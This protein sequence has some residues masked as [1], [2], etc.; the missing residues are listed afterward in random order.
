MT[1]CQCEDIQD[2]AVG[3]L[4]ACLCLERAPHW[5]IE[6]LHSNTGVNQ[7]EGNQTP[8]Y[9]SNTHLSARVGQLNPEWNEDLEDDEV[10]DRFQ[11]AVELT[12]GEFEGKVK[13]LSK[14]GSKQLAQ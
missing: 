6:T 12:G 7:W 14:V 8:K 4:E 1:Q 9:V 10:D 2:Q 5:V 13:W 3:L 11:E